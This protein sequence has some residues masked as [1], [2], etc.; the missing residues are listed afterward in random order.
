MQ[1]KVFG[2]IPF[3]IISFAEHCFPK[4]IYFK[5]TYDDIF[6]FLEI[7]FDM[8]IHNYLVFELDVMYCEIITRE[9]KNKHVKNKNFNRTGPKYEKKQCVFHYF[10][11]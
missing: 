10:N 8:K 7:D 11:D 5:N 2:S 6:K 1:K 4:R 3:S 9:A